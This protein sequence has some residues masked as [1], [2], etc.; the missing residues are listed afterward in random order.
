MTTTNRRQTP[1]TGD[2]DWP[3]DGLERVPL[4]PVCGS[5]QRQLR[6]TALEDNI[7][8]CAPGR[9]ALW[10]CDKCGCGYLDPRPTPAAIGLAYADYYTHDAPDEGWLS[11]ATRMGYRLPT[12]RNAYLNARFPRLGLKPS[13]PFCGGLLKL[14]PATRELAE[15]DVRHL[16]AP[17][18][19]AC[20]LDIGCGSGA[21]V[22]RARALGYRAEGLEFDADAVASA[23]AAGLPVRLGALP[24]TGL[25]AGTYDV[26]TLSQVIEHVHDPRAALK[27]CFRLLKSGGWFWLATPNM[28]APG[29]Q[30]F[31][32]DW[33]GLEPPRHLVLF[34]PGGLAGAL[35]D[36]GFADIHYLPPGQVSEWFY[37]ASERVRNRTPRSQPVTLSAELRQAAQAVDRATRRDPA[38]GEE[39]VVMARKP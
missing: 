31:G 19:G 24:D 18:P 33:R 16:P 12:M 14:F 22:K 10:R 39:L 17:A 21:F 37:Q 27:E 2:S 9:W 25:E 29:H 36:A 5:D 35:A 15:R 30:R 38:A 23:V 4:C 6:H 1:S 13:W 8:H 11:S 7:F 3:A 32:P 28:A 34:S 20:L 26:L